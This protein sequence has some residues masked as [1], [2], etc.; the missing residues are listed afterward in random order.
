MRCMGKREHWDAVAD[1]WEQQSRAGI[2]EP[3]PYGVVAMDG[4]P[5]DDHLRILDIGCG[6]GVTTVELAQ[7]SGRHARVTGV[8]LSPV[9]IRHA[10]D[11]AKKVWERGELTPDN[12]ELR[13]ADAEVD[14]LGRDHD[15]VFSRF[16]VMFFDDP[17][18]GFTNL[19]GALRPDGWLSFVA[20]AHQAANPW[21]DLPATAAA[22]T[23][24]IDPPGPAPTDGPGPFS[25]AD[26]AATTRLLTAAGFDRIDVIDITQDRTIRHGH[27]HDWIARQLQKGPARDAYLAADEA[28]RTAALHAA[29]GALEPYRQKG[30]SGGWRVPAHARAFIA[31]R[32]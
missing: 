5:L 17:T 1:V 30:P 18:V 25:L 6:P 9:M 2:D 4:I 19:A 22:A 14:D 15:V 24:G 29:L 32:V 26:P 21:M 20:W 12:I 3:D 31:R 8:D 28:T 13:V 23:L 11:R 7:R 10:R 27:E 16:G